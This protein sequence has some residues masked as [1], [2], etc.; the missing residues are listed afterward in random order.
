L[1]QCLLLLLLL[2]HL[3]L[4]LRLNLRLNLLL[5]PPPHVMMCY[6]CTETS[7]AMRGGSAR[8]SFESEL[9]ATYS[10]LSLTNSKTVSYVEH[11]VPI[12]P[13]IDVNAPRAMPLMLTKKERKRIRRQRRA[14]REKEKQDKV[15]L[16]LLPPPAPKVKISN[17]MRVLGSEAVADPTKIENEV[18]KQMEERQR[19]HDMRNLARK[20][21]PEE[22]KEK[23]RRKNQ[24][25][26]EDG[27]HVALF[28]V[29]DLSDKQ[30]RFKVD[31]NAQESLLTGCVV[32]CKAAGTN[33]VV[34][35][36]GACPFSSVSHCRRLV[37]WLRDLVTR[38]PVLMTHV[39]SSPLPT[40]SRS[41]QSH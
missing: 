28:R 3:L 23:A 7:S 18:R 10:E 21:T 40:S 38:V 37:L 6:C 19:N 9:T 36:G 32:I 35:E 29:R 41:C 30:H 16:G 14:E 26:M 4:N 13:T 15:R 31:V 27:V 33:L 22:R 12:Q 17:L 8:S 39:S 1:A 20:L 24:K 2:L 25:G 34:V 5:L 11:P